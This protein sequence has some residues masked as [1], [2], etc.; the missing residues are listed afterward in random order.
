MSTNALPANL[1]H[2]WW[3]VAFYA[4]IC[5]IQY[6][7]WKA[8]FYWLTPKS[9]QIHVWSISDPPRQQSSVSVLLL[10]PLRWVSTPMQQSRPFRS[11]CARVLFLPDA[12]ALHVGTGNCCRAWFQNQV[13]QVEFPDCFSWLSLSTDQRQSRVG[14]FK[15]SSGIHNNTS[16]DDTLPSTI[17]ILVSLNS[18]WASLT[19]VSS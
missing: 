17:N 11:R 2:P 15:K 18:G 3:R 12:E 10:A 8:T 4:K 7:M 13:Q 16:M 19:L 9:H 14:V 6:V 1:I 5:C